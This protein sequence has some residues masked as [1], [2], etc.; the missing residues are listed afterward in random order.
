[1]AEIVRGIGNGQ[2]VPEAC[3]G[4]PAAAT[5]ARMPAPTT[6]L[7]GPAVSAGP[8]TP[9]PMPEGTGSPSHLPQG[10]HLRFGPSGDETPGGKRRGAAE[11]AE[12]FQRGQEAIKD[13]VAMDM[14]PPTTAAPVPGAMS[15]TE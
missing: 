11:D 14:E 15:Q 7:R 10:A 6:P 4:P 5:P 8:R 12:A 1:M 13:G 2:Q 3:K 9:N